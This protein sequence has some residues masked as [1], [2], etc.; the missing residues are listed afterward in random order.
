MSRWFRFY[1][2]ALNDPKVDRLNPTLYKTWVKLLCLACENGGKLPS[3]D[4]IAYA[5]RLSVQDA[6]QHV[7]ELILY[8][9][10][11]IAAD[12]TRSPHNWCSRQY[13]SD[14]STDRSRKHRARRNE[15]ATLHDRCAGVA[16]T[17]PDQTRTES[18]SEPDQNASEEKKQAG[19]D[20]K[21]LLGGFG[22]GGDLARTISADVKRKVCEEHRLSDCEPLV[23]LFWQWDAKKPRDQR[24][25]KPDAVFKSAAKKLLSGLDTEERERIRI[26]S[27][28]ADK[29]PA[30]AS[31][32]LV[33]A[34]RKGS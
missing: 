1:A 27:V 10:I 3:T 9:L 15:D 24:A 29:P 30:K 22:S 26:K 2:E 12:G 16:E 20:F 28:A 32:S 14:S 19:L 4:D 31:Q 5:L 23:E 34:L 13:V 21:A 8:C 25:R 18:D 33:A 7:D 11:D 17:P 6:Q